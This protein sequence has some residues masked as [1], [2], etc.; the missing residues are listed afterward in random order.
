MGTNKQEKQWKRISDIY[1]RYSNLAADY[2]ADEELLVN[3][4]IF[5]LKVLVLGRS[6]HDR[7]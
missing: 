1:E 3:M 5:E 2:P 4:R 7:K 6:K